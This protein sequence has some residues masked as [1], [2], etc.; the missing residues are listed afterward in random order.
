MSSY[1]CELLVEIIEDLIEVDRVRTNE[2]ASSDASQQIRLELRSARCRARQ[3]LAVARR[4]RL[5]DVIE[6]LT[7][8]GRES[9]G[10]IYTIFLRAF[11][12]MLT[13]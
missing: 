10:V 8:G 7:L 11:L 13:T 4:P 2:D 1:I 6:L 3:D 12:I 5:R 9:V